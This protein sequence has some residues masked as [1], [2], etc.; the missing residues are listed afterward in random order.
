MPA[1]VAILV[2]ALF[3]SV[4]EYGFNWINST[5]VGVLILSLLVLIFGGKQ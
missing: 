2:F 3:M 4:H 1:I 5:L